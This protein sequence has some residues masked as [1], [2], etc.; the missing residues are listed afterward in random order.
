MQQS[1]FQ[2]TAGVGSKRIE[3]D[4]MNAYGSIRDI[5]ID[6]QSFNP[7]YYG[8]V[9][10]SRKFIVHYKNEDALDMGGPGTELTAL[11]MESLGEF[12][13]FI[14]NEDCCSVYWFKVSRIMNA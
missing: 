11:F 5:W 14:K 6:M 12:C 10:W 13:D 7:A 9:L 3:I 2:G 1:L 4:R 8:N